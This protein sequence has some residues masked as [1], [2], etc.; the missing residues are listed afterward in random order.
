MGFTGVVQGVSGE[1]TFFVRFQDGCKKNL[2]SNQLTAVTAQKIPMY[3]E[4]E[5][6]T[7]SVIPDNTVDS[8]KGWYHGVYAM[9]YFT[10]D[11]GFNR[12]QEQ[13]D[14][15]PDPDEEEIEYVRLEK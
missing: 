4:P 6:P 15:N 12:K 8:E 13:V 2:T 3:Q 5:V 10:K 9:Q 14:M 7:I 11:N 1:R